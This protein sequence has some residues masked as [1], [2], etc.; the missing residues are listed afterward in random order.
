MH[1]ENNV[2]KKRVGRRLGIRWKMLS[3]ILVFIF[4]FTMAMWVF[5]IQ[6]LIY[7]YQGVK[8][9][10]I[11]KTVELIDNV[12]EDNLK[13]LETVSR[14]A[15]ETYDDIWVYRIRDGELSENNP[16]VF[17][18]GS[19]DSQAIFLQKY[20]DDFYLESKNNSNRYI[21]VFSVKYFMSDGYY[22]LDIVEDNKGFPENTHI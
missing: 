21:C 7:F 15:E 13:V 6:M 18:K 10:E 2:S 1:K 17:S 19:H 20:F 4:L 8:Y 22:S 12:K 16:I 3:I 9:R 11:N 5:Q 14:R